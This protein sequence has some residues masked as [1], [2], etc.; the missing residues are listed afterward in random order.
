[1]RNYEIMLLISAN[2]TE[3]QTTKV[4]AEF[5]A[6]ITKA[7]GKITSED[8]WGRRELAYP[9]NKET[10]GFYV[11]LRFDFEPA[12]LIELERNLGL[13]KD[14]LRHLVTLPI[15]SE[16]EIKYADEIEEERKRRADKKALRAKE[17]KERAKVEDEKFKLKSERQEKKMM[18]KIE[19]GIHEEKVAP[20]TRTAP[21]A[22]AAPAAPVEKKE[23]KQ[24]DKFEEKLSKIIDADLDL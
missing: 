7:K 14:I 5:K 23:D 17:D 18:R 20:V 3:A 13:N 12:G 22:P 19:E 10:E 15:A 2:F 4:L 21:V 9:V 16:K 8:I 24:D 11:V 1:M 6:E